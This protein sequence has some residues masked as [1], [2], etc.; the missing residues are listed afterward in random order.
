[1]IVRLLL[2][3]VALLGLF[4]CADYRPLYG[5]NESGHSVSVDLAAVAVEEQS[6]RVGQVVRNDLLSGLGNSPA[7]R[8][9]LRLNPVE[10]VIPISSFSAS[11]P[12]RYRYNLVV[13]Y[14]LVNLATGK[15]VTSGRSFSNVSYDNINQPVSDLSAMNNA[16]ER[17]AH[18]VAQDLRQ[19]IAA[20]LVATK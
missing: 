11:L 6:T 13:Q 2:L 8:Y 14:S 5:Q 12:S 3:T 7:A 16:M 9:T 10:K 18:E 20:M 19:R 1:M 17:A 4:G 15:T